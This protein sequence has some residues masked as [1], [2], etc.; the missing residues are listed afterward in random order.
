[1]VSDVCIL[2]ATLLKLSPL[3]FIVA[4]LNVKEGEEDARGLLL[5][6]EDELVGDAVDSS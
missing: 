3:L 5:A 4:P 2:P 1:M 6:F